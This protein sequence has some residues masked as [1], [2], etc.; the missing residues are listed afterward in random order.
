M[1]QIQKK[2]PD[3]HPLFSEDEVFIIGAGHF[4]KRAVEVLSSQIN[5]PLRVVEKNREALRLITG[6]LVK[7]IENDG[8]SFLVGS[9]H[10][11]HPTNIIVPAVPIHLAYEWLLL[12][13]K[14]G[15]GVCK[16][17]VPESIKPL[18]PHTWEGSE[19][20]LLVSYANFRCPEDCP[21]PSDYCTVTG[22]KR[23]TPLH[24]LLNDI[25]PARFRIHV[26]QSRQLAPG[27]GGYSVGDL[28]KLLRRVESGGEGKWLVATACKC[29]GVV[30]AME[31]KIGKPIS[32]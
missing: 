16:I 9:F 8:V 23:G 19:D 4:G 30:S 31:V 28:Q 2:K 15:L 32:F 25:A 20:S 29:H 24:A 18:L 10:L 1:S 14:R 17:R 3:S 11:L 26:L 27:V 12:S 21:E 6:S 13:L 5:S 22:K 7:R